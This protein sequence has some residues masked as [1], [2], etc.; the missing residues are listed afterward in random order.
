M[1]RTPPLLVAAS[2]LL[3]QGCFPFATLGRAR[4]VEPGEIEVWGAPSALV[5]A[6]STGG[7]VRPVVVGGVRYGLTEVVELDAGLSSSGGSLGT[8]LQLARSPSLSQGLDLALA[9]SLVFTWPDKLAVDLPLLLGI[10][11]PE[12]NQLVLA[13][14]AA[15]QQRYGA[16]GVPHPINYAYLGGSVGFAWQ[17]SEHLALMPEVAMLTEI[18][19][20]PGWSSNVVDAV[21]VQAGVGLLFEL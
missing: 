13:A 15:Y 12:R 10:N 11:L 18:Y 5:V 17:V 2:A 19:A 1:N 9:P 3:L 7:S 14:R 8:R 6:T 20:D 21:G 16:G 4:V